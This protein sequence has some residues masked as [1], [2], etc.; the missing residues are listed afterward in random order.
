MEKFF[1]DPNTKL[2]AVYYNE[3]KPPHLHRICTDVSL[4]GLKG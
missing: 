4:S 3:E 2:A 1:F